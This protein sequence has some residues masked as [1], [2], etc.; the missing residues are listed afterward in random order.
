LSVPEQPEII[1][2]VEQIVSEQPKLEPVKLVK[3][4]PAKS[5]KQEPAEPEKIEPVQSE[6]AIELS[7]PEE[8]EP[9][10]LEKIELSPEE[11][12]NF[13]DRILNEEDEDNVGADGIKLHEALEQGLVPSDFNLE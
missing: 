11:V 1:E 3:K 9:I 10:Q 6:Q 13:W 4:E 7:E 5:K 2:P 8:L 12:N